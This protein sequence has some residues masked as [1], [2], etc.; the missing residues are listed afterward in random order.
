M[1]TM[2][3]YTGEL[4]KFQ[5]MGIKARSARTQRGILVV[6]LDFELYW[7]VRDVTTLDQCQGKLV[8]ARTAIPA[9]LNLFVEFGV[10]ATWATVGMLF[11]RSKKELFRL[12][13]MLRPKYS[14]SEFSP[15]EEL[16]SLGL[17][18][19]SDPCRY[20]R[21]LIETIASTP[22]Q[23]IGSHTFSHFYCLEDGQDVDS[24][25]CDLQSAL[26]VARQD[27][28]EVKSLVFP[29]N[30]INPGYLSACKELGIK[31]YRGTAAGWIYAARK[32]ENESTRRRGVRLL[33]FYLNLSGHNTYDLKDIHGIPVNVPASRYLWMHSPLLGPLKPLAV[34]RVR[35]DMKHAARLGRLYHLWFH[36]EDVGVHLEENL[37]FLRRIFE[38]YAGAQARGEMESLSM[39][40]FAKR[41]EVLR[42]GTNECAISRRV[43]R[44]A[45]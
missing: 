23:E 19:Q 8:A 44:G 36:P 6:S 28:I 9:L 11:A 15:Y 26:C 17:T 7:G 45:V 41:I 34:R 5:N 43:S 32:R 4:R 33:D 31:A 29:R 38:C 3:K 24:F 2:D 40:E 39:G 30:Q 21:S 10:H 16:D 35:N 27:G 20:A 12:I 42:S 14:R 22:H 18:E 37:Q 25:R 13:P 1:K